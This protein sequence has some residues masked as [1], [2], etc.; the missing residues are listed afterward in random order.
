MVTE[1]TFDLN[2]SLVILLV[3]NLFNYPSSKLMD[4]L[5]DWKFIE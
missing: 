1:A 4:Q 2:S 5:T 3:R